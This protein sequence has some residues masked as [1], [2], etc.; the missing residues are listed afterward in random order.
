MLTLPLLIGIVCLTARELDRWRLS[1]SLLRV[2][3]FASLAKVRLMVRLAKLTGEPA[4]LAIASWNAEQEVGFLC[5]EVNLKA[6]K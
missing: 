1:V 4:K 6:E 2:T 3:R 5:D